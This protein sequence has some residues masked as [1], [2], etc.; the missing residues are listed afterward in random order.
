[1]LIPSASSTCQNSVS[2]Q[3]STVSILW[4][5][6]LTTVLDAHALGSAMPNFVQACRKSG[7]P[8]F[9]S[10]APF[11]RTVKKIHHKIFK[12]EPGESQKIEN[13][14]DLIRSHVDMDIIRERLS[15]P[16]IS[17]DTGE[18][19]ISRVLS[20][21]FRMFGKLLGRKEGGDK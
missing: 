10:D 16:D 18:G 15:N 8:L 14:V 19:I 7:L 11:E 4:S 6:I 2:F 9:R 20:S 13:I 12:V 5:I 21:P 17:V 3:I 1:M